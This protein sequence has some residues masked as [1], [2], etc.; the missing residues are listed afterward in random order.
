MIVHRNIG[1]S[2]DN[3][4]LLSWPGGRGGER[5]HSY[6]TSLHIAT[7]FVC[8]FYLGE[9]RLSARY[10]QMTMMRTVWDVMRVATFFM[11]A[12]LR[13]D[14]AEKLETYFVCP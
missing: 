7:V 14:F 4:L 10:A 8:L 9:T 2:K 1:S 5:G 12:S 11:P 13:V 3:L 6:K